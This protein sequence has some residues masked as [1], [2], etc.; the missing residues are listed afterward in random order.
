MR[1]AGR[2]RIHVLS[3]LLGLW[4]VLGTTGLSNAAVSPRSDCLI[5]PA[6]DPGIGGVYYCPPAEGERYLIA[7]ARRSSTETG[8][9]EDIWVNFRGIFANRIWINIGM[10]EA[11]DASLPAWDALASLIAWMRVI[12]AGDVEALEAFLAPLE[13]NPTF[14]EA[15]RALK[16]RLLT[17]LRASAGEPADAPLRVVLYHVHLMPPRQTQKRLR[18]SLNPLLSIPSQEDLLYA[19]RLTTLAPESESKIA[20]PAGIWTYTWDQTQALRFVSEYY[21]GPAEAPFALKYR[22]VYMH[23]AAQESLRQGL[24]D[25]TAITPERLKH[26]IE[27]LRST[28]AILHFAF[29]TDW[30]TAWQGGDAE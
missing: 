18:I 10:H 11:S 9:S 26:Y 12:K 6:F 19:P 15:D 29:A 2:Q 21:N 13:I 8:L 27:T 20:V 4:Y 17:A 30:P 25:P 7:H 16:Q 28:G 23:F 24:N 5:P 22:R 1:F 14:N 3:L